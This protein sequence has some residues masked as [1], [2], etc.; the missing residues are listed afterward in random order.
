V[1][2]SRT[3]VAVLLMAPVMA[4][5]AMRWME[6]IRLAIPIEP[7]CGTLEFSVNAG[8]NQRLAA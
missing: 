8:L 5:V 7:R 3:S 1:C 6:A 4:K 2:T